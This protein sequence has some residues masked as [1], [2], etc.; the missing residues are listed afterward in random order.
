MQRSSARTI[1]VTGLNATD[2]PG[3]GVA[4]LRSLRHG[5]SETDRLIGLPQQHR[6]AV[7]AQMAPAK[8]DGHLPAAQR[9]K[10]E[11][12]LLTVCRRPGAGFCLSWFVHTNN[13][14]ASAPGLSVHV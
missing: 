9:L 8:I 11:R 5:G 14:A 2:N 1:A 3:P 6:P 7:A 10:V 4:V 13:L 12:G